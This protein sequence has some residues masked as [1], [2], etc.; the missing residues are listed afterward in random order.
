MSK[1]KGRVNAGIFMLLAMGCTYKVPSQSVEQSIP[2]ASPVAASSEERATE[3]ELFE[4]A[5][6]SRDPNEPPA[7]ESPQKRDYVLDL[8]NCTPERAIDS[9]TT[10]WLTLQPAYFPVKAR[11]VRIRMKDHVLETR[12]NR[13]LRAMIVKMFKSYRYENDDLGLLKDTHVFEFVC[14]ARRFR[15]HVLSV[16]CSYY[17]GGGAHPL[18]GKEHY[19]FITCG[20]R[21][22]DLQIVNFC[23]RS[24]CNLDELDKVFWR[25]HEAIYGSEDIDS[26]EDIDLVEG[27]NDR[28]QNNGPTFTN[29]LL[30]K[31]GVDF[32]LSFPHTNQHFEKIAVSY[33]ELRPIFASAP[34]FEQIWSMKP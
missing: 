29:M 16:H 27:I 23:P 3:S 8:Q 22:V 13:E 28:C 14:D 5:E 10:E 19:N 26:S 9:I 6:Y 32:Y 18:Y 12:L 17:Y 1:Q 2:S 30:T 25:K 34:L 33:K 21:P 24:T 31:K 15:S 20:E 11:R 7:Y 4:D